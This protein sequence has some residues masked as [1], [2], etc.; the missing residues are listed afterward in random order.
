MKPATNPTTT[1]LDASRA[2]KSV[3]DAV[4]SATGGI[5]K[6]ADKYLMNVKGDCFSRPE[7]TRP[8]KLNDMV[9][10]LYDAFQKGKSE[11]E[12]L[13]VPDALAR[14]IR[15]WYE[16]QPQILDVDVAHLHEERAEAE[17]EIAEAEARI[18]QSGPVLQRLRIS[19][20]NHF[21]ARETYIRSVEQKSLA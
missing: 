20:R 8:I 11:G 19:H 15:Q 1:E 3:I 9:A 14:A 7:R 18:D 17:A 21:A 6:P 5:P 2:T 12:L 4:R 13:E 10:L 16:T